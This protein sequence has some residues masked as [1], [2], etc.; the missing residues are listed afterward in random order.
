MPCLSTLDLAAFRFGKQ[1]GWLSQWAIL[2]TPDTNASATSTRAR[3]VLG[4]KEAKAVGPSEG[5]HICGNV[6]DII[7]RTT[8]EGI[9]RCRRIAL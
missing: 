7:E 9:C 8:R 3:L 4:A 5:F 1:H 2:V 6:V